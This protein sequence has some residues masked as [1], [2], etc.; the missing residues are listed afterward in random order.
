MFICKHCKKELNLTRPSD[1]ANHSRWCESNPKKLEYLKKLSEAREKISESTIKKISD[2]VKLAHQT[3][4]YDYEAQSKK[5]KETRIKNG[6]TK[7]SPEAIEKIRQGA[8]KSNHRRLV[9]SIREYVKKDGTIVLLDSSWEEVL[10]KRLDHL[11]IIWERPSVPVI[12]Q[13]DGV[14]RR[15]FPDFYLPEYDLYLDPKN[16]AA[17]SAQSRKIKILLDMMKNLVI[18]RSLSE[19]ENFNINEHK[20]EVESLRPRQNF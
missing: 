1:K 15:Y 13:I 20:S 4:K 17:Y 8:L 12:Y 14:P 3:G 6:T 18:I 16:P 7:H 11:N 2:S 19:C 5:K 10:A 9:R